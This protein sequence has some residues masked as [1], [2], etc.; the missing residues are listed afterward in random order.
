MFC[1]VASTNACIGHRMAWR[2]GASETHEREN[3][4]GTITFEKALT[5]RSRTTKT[6]EKSD[7][8]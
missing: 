5:S 8:V 4:R 3:A 2:R 6:G 7:D 1:G